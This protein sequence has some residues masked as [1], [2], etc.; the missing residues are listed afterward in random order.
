MDEKIRDATFIERLM[1]RLGMR[2]GFA[3]EGN[4]MRP[5]LREGE[6]VLIQKGST[7]RVGEV[8][9][10]CHPYKQSVRIIKRITKIHDPDRYELLGDDPGES[11]DSRTFG[12]IEGAM[13]LGKVVARLPRQ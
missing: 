4:S 13:I 8:V 7:L 11:T 10:A 3:V 5:V 12:P 2:K 9:I 1:L 6:A